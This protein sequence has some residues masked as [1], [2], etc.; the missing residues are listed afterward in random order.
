MI[1]KLFFTAVPLAPRPAYG[2]NAVQS[3][4]IVP[5]CGHRLT[6]QYQPRLRRPGSRSWE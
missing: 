5:R 2:A 3:G 6:R 4:R 1:K